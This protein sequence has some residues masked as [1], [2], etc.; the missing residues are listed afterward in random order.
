MMS[1]LHRRLVCALTGGCEGRR[2]SIHEPSRRYP[3]S[4]LYACA[5]CRR[6]WVWVP[7]WSVLAWSVLEA[8]ITAPHAWVETFPSLE[9]SD[10]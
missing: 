7:A 2:V 9:W 8:R 6:L 5:T 10:A 4:E 3:T 1:W